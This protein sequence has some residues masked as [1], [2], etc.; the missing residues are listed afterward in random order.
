MKFLAK[1]NYDKGLVNYDDL[2][3]EVVVLTTKRIEINAKLK[4]KVRTKEWKKNIEEEKEMF[5]INF[6]ARKDARDASKVNLVEVPKKRKDSKV[7]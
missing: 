3:K 1:I 2:K 5:M 6:D 7:K 4:E